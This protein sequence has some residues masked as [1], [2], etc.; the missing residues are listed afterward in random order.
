MKVDKRT[1]VG[2]IA[3]TILMLSG[4]V[5]SQVANASEP[6]IGEIRAFGFNFCP[7]NWAFTDGQLLKI[8]E[9]YSLY[10]LLGTRYG[11]NGTTTF[12]LPNLKGRVL[13]HQ[14]P[15]FWM[16]ESGGAST[17]TLV[18]SQ[19]PSHT[20][21]A[22]VRASSSAGSSSTPSSNTVLA[23]S[24]NGNGIYSSTSPDV[25]LSNESLQIGATGNGHPIENKQPYTVVNYC[26]AL[27]GIFPP[28][29]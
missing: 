28:R 17:V 6:F 20:H 2:F 19:L 16:G 21:T 11:G 4:L 12:A 22:S 23:G 26:I 27:D 18:A 10:A 3:G 8:E 7:K 5:G 1:G 9:N 25:A 24:A 15:G 14:G 29:Y 13:V